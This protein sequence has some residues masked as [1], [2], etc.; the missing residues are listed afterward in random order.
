MNPVVE[1]LAEEARKQG[2]ISFAR[3]VEVALYC[4]VYG[5]YDRETDTIGRCG[6]F[7]TSVSVGSLFG[8]MLAWQLAEW[9][10]GREM[11]QGTPLKWIEAGAHDGRLAGDILGWLR[12]RRPE[13]FERVGYCIVEPSEVRRRRQ[14][15]TLAEF[16]EKVT[17]VKNVSDLAAGD[18]V[19]GFIFS[20]ELLDAFPVHRLGWD[21]PARAWF[22]WGVS[23]EGGR[24]VWKRMVQEQSCGAAVQLHV[25][26]ELAEVLPDGF[27]TEISPAATQWWSEAAGVLRR[28]KLLTFDYGLT[29]E[30]FLAPHR[31]EGTLRGYHQHHLVT[32]VLANTGGQDLTAHVNFSAIEAA[33][34]TGGLKTEVLDS[35]E[36]FLTQIAGRIWAAPDS[37]G[38]WT[39]AHTRQFQT[40]T[41]PE[42][43]GRKFRVLIQSRGEPIG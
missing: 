27:S 23:F 32:D 25:A 29:A 28:G 3:F 31:S 10:A 14:E 30:E 39:P 17:W 11:G 2:A 12:G 19:H 24:F 15:K 41:H 34:A 1:I 16:T 9:S 35:Q 40:L 33:G 8:E 38:P 43:L 7:F 4:P 5:Y 20:N 22:E 37:F 26:P 6:D 13:L 42:H 36:K 21:A 18:G